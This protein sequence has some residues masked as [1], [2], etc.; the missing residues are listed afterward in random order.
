[1]GKAGFCFTTRV[2]RERERATTG[3]ISLCLNILLN[4]LK[5]YTNEYRIQ[6]T[7]IVSNKVAYDV[8]V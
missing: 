6:N 8:V 7:G 2:W 4:N 3:G 5:K 1:M